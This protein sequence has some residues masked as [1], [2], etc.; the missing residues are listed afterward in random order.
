MTE[1]PSK[2]PRG[3]PP[4]PQGAR[5]QAEIQRAY[6]ERKRMATPD[7]A[8]FAAM[9]DELHHALSKITLLEEDRARWQADCA[10]AEAALKQEERRHTNTIKDKIV[11]QQE[12]AA[13]KK[14]P[15]R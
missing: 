10:K 8:D 2:R 15:R 1:T 12:L 14:K 5:S 6:R 7:P 13:L 3:R 4:T 9:R 11:L